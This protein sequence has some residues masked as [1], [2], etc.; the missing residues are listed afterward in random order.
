MRNRSRTRIICTG[1]R[2]VALFVRHQQASR[3]P[4]AQRSATR[5]L[6]LLLL[7]L[8]A[9]CRLVGPAPPPKNLDPAAERAFAEAQFH[10]RGGGPESLDLARSAAL[11]AISLAPDWVAPHRVIDDLDRDKLLGPELLENYEVLLDEDPEHAP[12]LYLAARLDGTV[13]ADERFKAA[14]Q[15]D[16]SLSWGYHGLAWTRALVGDLRGASTAE[17]R[18]LSYARGS[19]ERSF[20]TEALARRFVDRGLQVLALDIL[21]E[22]LAEDDLFSSDRSVLSVHA[23]VI[24]MSLPYG[25]R[26]R[27]GA[28]RALELLRQGGITDTEVH[29]LVLGLLAAKRTGTNVELSEILIALRGIDSARRDRLAAELMLTEAKTPLAVG[30]LKRSMGSESAGLA[31]S[32]EMRSAR[33]AVGELEAVIGDWLAEQPKFLLDDAGLPKD[34]KL[35]GMVLAAGLAS[36]T[37]ASGEKHTEALVAFGESLL[38]AGWFIEAGGLAEAMGAHNLDLGLDLNHRA[39]AGKALIAS[40]V[41]LINSIDQNQPIRV[42][43]PDL[44]RP[45][46]EVN[47]ADLDELLVAMEPRFR[48]FRATSGKIRRRSDVDLGLRKSPR[49]RFGPVGSVIH[50]GP[51]F[52]DQ[53]EALGLG[54]AGEQVGGLA[55]AFGAIG[56]F[57]V[58]GEAVGSGGPDGT[59]LRRLLVEERSGSHFGMPWQGTI[60]WCDGADLLSRPGRRGARI[61][62]AAL[63]EGYWID[64]DLLRNEA[65]S[66]RDLQDKYF[67]VDAQGDLVRA[68]SI[69]PLVRGYAEAGQ[70]PPL[71]GE[72]DRVRLALMRDRVEQSKTL[73]ASARYLSSELPDLVSLEELV[74][75]T[76][77]HEEGHLCDRTRF[78]PLGDRVWSVLVFFMQSGMSGARVEERLEYRAQLTALCNIEETRIALAEVLSAA[79]QGVSGITPH[80]AAYTRLLEDFLKELDRALDADPSAW[81]KLDRNA[82]LAHQMHRLSAN[83]VRAIGMKLAVIEGLLSD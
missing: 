79:E 70:F 32:P 80:A 62:G 76:A 60:A 83:E 37:K 44:S 8:C 3:K 61:G 6:L 56:R 40:L 16:S 43:E 19:W 45:S 1:A 9:A 52:S 55:A 24:S 2:I 50:P 38:D 81:S 67:G 54:Q 71:L 26:S 36:Q 27:E 75:Y 34:A 58:F 64:V 74:L 68:L 48:Q 31:L 33:F 51:N 63:H 13:R 23:S 30:L 66:Y 42:A 65:R 7:F 35:R 18:A 47:S 4:G 11:R 21:L 17:R 78:L 20:F 59:V 57:A 12:T 53:D 28:T 69:K 22:R 14:I 41:T 5:Q 46:K 39:L 25:I 49:L 29:S 72:S 15:A 73:S 10:L 77:T 82:H